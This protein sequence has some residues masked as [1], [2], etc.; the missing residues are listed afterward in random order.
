MPSHNFSKQACVV[1]HDGAGLDPYQLLSPLF[2]EHE[3]DE[4]L[5]RLAEH[6]GEVIANGAA[7]M[8]A[9]ARLRDPLVPKVERVKLHLQL[10]RYCATALL[11]TRH[12]RNGDGVRGAQ[13]LGGRCGLIG[14]D[15]A[16]REGRLAIAPVNDV[17]LRSTRATKLAWMWSSCDAKGSIR[18]PGSAPSAQPAAGSQAAIRDHI[19]RIR[20]IAATWGSGS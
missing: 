17:Q 7:T 18:R 15:L 10:L 2:R 14:A 3:L 9:Y 11:R 13:G 8:I 1:E 5:A 4:A 16:L 20:V 6:E 12:A 19:A